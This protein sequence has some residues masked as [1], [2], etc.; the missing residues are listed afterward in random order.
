MGTPDSWHCS[1]RSVR[2]GLHLGCRGRK[3]SVSPLTV[4][5]CLWMSAKLFLAADI[6][7][8][9]RNCNTVFWVDK[10]YPGRGRGLGRGLDIK[11]KIFVLS[12]EEIWWKLQIH[13]HLFSIALFSS[14][15]PL[16]PSPPPLPLP[17]PPL[18]PLPLPPPSPPSPSSP[19]L[20]LPLF[21][22]QLKVLQPV[23]T[24]GSGLP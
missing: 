12:W 9:S 2:G 3:S 21:S 22:L 19:P 17:P 6:S 14:T 23:I 1:G 15:S 11:S 4:W 24:S 13:F 7:R 8:K 10:L 18:R 5:F 16:P 20:P